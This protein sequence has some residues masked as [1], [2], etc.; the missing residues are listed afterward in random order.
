MLGVKGVS[1]QLTAEARDFFIK[2]R[3]DTNRRVNISALDVWQAQGAAAEYWITHAMPLAN[4][5][6]V[7]NDRKVRDAINGK[8][9]KAKSRE[10]EFGQTSVL[11]ILDNQMQDIARNSTANTAKGEHWM[12]YARRKAGPALLGLKMSVN[13]KQPLSLSTGV[14]EYAAMGST[15]GERPAAIMAKALKNMPS[16]IV[17]AIKYGK[18]G[19]KNVS[20]IDQLIDRV[21]AIEERKTGRGIDPL[22]DDM[23]EQLRDKGSESKQGYIRIRGRQMKRA[24]VEASMKGIVVMDRWTLRAMSDFIIRNELKGGATEAQAVAAAQRAIE[25]T[26]PMSGNL[27]L[28]M[29]YRSGE[30]VRGMT[31][32]TGEVNQFGN[33]G[34]QVIRNM[35]GPEAGVEDKEAALLLLMILGMNTYLVSAIDSAGRSVDPREKQS[36]DFYKMNLGRFAGMAAGG[37]LGAFTANLAVNHLYY[38]GVFSDSPAPPLM[39][40]VGGVGGKAFKAWNKPEPTQLKALAKELTSAAG[41]GF[42]LPLSGAWN[43][44]QGL[45]DAIRGG[46]LDLNA[47]TAASGFSRFSRGVAASSK[48]GR[49][50]EKKK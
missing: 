38:D 22:I 41:L 7:L 17:R 34:Q 26:Q 45:N 30:F 12:A 31:L 20:R 10:P 16:A 44:I 4:A 6:A 19:G 49:P 47:I 46:E 29:A 33:L 35:V 23:I 48:T 5:E 27:Y 39:S 3:G 32:F 28:P 13:L 25:K 21:P 24:L 11:Q 37:V 18:G 1:D 50:A 15:T 36:Q 2:S 14:F 43:F 9:G 8:Y 42:G 40:A